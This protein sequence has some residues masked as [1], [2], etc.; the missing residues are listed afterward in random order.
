MRVLIA[1][2]GTGGHLFPGIAM[3]EAFRMQEPAAR[4]L[5]V[6]TG[7]PMEASALT[8]RGLD[9]VRIPAEGLKGQGFPRQIQ[10]LL[11]I[12]I[13]I[14][15][16]AGIIRKFTPHIVIGVGGYSSGPV[17]LAA[18][19]AGKTIVIHEQNILP[20]FTNR[21]LGHLADRIFLSFPDRYRCFNPSKTVVTGNPVRRELLAGRSGGGK[22]R[23]F[24]ILIVGGSQGAHAINFAMIE[25]LDHLKRPKQIAFIHQTGAKDAAWVR[26]AYAN[27]GIPAQVEPF[28][29]DMAGPYIDA[30]LVVCRA[31]ATTISELSALGKPAVLIPFPF[32]ANNH[33]EFNARYVADAGGAEVILQKNLTGRGLAA[34]LDFY[35]STPPALDE[36][37]KQTSTLARPDAA[38]V[39]VDECRRLV[40]AGA[41]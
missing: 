40:G 31:G 22:E 19:G 10:S 39:I 28:F 29:P 21:M 11:R 37:S 41:R 16:A 36:M 18:R 34:R 38:D 1:G 2:G 33:Q 8:N 3:A 30:H 6:G 35:R 14:A 23:P 26:E 32:A 13:G 12:P 15:R 20:G 4:I 17:A 25:A 5:F 9:H 27:R 7:K 24:T